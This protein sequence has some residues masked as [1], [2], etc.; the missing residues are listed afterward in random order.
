MFIGGTCGYS[1]GEWQYWGIVVPVV[2]LAFI[3]REIGVEK[4]KWTC[5]E[6]NEIFTNFKKAER[7]VNDCIAYNDIRRNDP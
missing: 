2:V 6:C 4:E 5:P 3:A 7:H 1:L